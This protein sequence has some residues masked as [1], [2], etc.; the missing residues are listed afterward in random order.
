MRIYQRIF[1]GHLLVKTD[2]LVPA[3]TASS[4]RVSMASAKPAVAVEE[5]TTPKPESKSCIIC[6]A[7]MAQRDR[8]CSICAAAKIKSLEAARQAQIRASPTSQTR[9]AREAKEYLLHLKKSCGKKRPV[10]EW[11]VESPVCKVVSFAIFARRCGAL[12]AASVAR[13]REP[14]LLWQPLWCSCGIS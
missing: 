14:H 5:A 4:S 11:V 9:A 3:D 12:C 13:A 8:F 7:V 6:G 2:P 1:G 10:K